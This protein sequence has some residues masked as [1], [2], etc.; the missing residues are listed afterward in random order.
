MS[1]HTPAYSLWAV[2]LCIEIPK[3]SNL[4]N[5]LNSAGNVRL[6]EIGDFDGHIGLRVLQV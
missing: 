4:L 6:G 1:I 5:G 2:A 3:V